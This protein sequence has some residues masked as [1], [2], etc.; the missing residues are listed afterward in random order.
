MR[1]DSFLSKV[2]CGSKKEVKSY[3]K[4][5]LIKVNN[6]VVNKVNYKIDLVV[7]I[8]QFKSEILKYEKFK[9]YMLNKPA[10]Y[11][12]ATEDKNQKVVMD[13]L[14]IDNKNQF[15]PVGRLDKDTEGL[16]VITNDGKLSHNILSPKKHISKKYYVQVEGI[17]DENDINMLTEG[18]KLKDNYICK[19]SIIQLI[20]IDSDNN[21]S[22]I[23]I[24][25]YEGKYHQIKRMIA[26][27]GKKV[28]YLKRVQMGN[29]ELDEDLK[30][31]QYKIL[32]E[33]EIDN[34]IN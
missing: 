34:M 20:D 12:T 14:D 32:S 19:P 31:G 29:L 8:I 4:N 7:D 17:I 15:F 25:I 18:I 23:Y 27:V 30:L 11:I 5:N 10:G 2:G 28:I 24:T 16:L 22:Y 3:I 6:K 9:Y 26:A 33:Q 13:L 1:L 21:I